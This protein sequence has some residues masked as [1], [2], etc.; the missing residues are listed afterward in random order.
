MK[1]F[2]INFFVVI[3]NIQHLDMLVKSISVL[4]IPQLIPREMFNGTNNIVIVQKSINGF[5]DLFV[6]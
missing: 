1:T 6:C 3:I 4:T 2:E 5:S